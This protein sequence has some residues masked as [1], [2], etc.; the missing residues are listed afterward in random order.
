MVWSGFGPY[1]GLCCEDAPTKRIGVI[2]T[3]GTKTHALG[4]GVLAP[5]PKL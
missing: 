5:Q 3:P 1:D 2:P 4:L